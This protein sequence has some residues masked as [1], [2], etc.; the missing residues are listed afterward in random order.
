MQALAQAILRDVGSDP[1]TC[2]ILVLKSPAHF[3]ADFGLMA[4]WVIVAEA[5]GLLAAD[6]ASR[7]FRHL[8]PGLRTWLNW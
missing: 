7:P 8:R 6:P 5:P 3:R 1:A 2:P 4:A